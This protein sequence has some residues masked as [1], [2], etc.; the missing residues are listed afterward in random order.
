M[1]E[2]QVPCKHCGIMTTMI[3]TQMCDPCWHVDRAATRNPDL[4][5]KVALAT[6]PELNKYKAVLIKIDHIAQSA[7]GKSANEME[8][9]LNQISNLAY[10]AIDQCQSS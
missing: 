5:Y 3:G 2:E 8:D 10:E 7:I 9:D 4:A 6:K 1:N